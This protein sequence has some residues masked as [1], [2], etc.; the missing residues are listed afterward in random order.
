MTHLKTFL[1]GSTALAL[2]A[3]LACGGGGGGSSAPAPAPT[4][5]SL[6][7]TDPTS[8]TYLLKKNTALSTATHLV[9]DLV[10]PSS[11]TGSGVTATFSADAT[12]VTW[13][14]V[15]A[16][17][18]TGTFVQNGTAFNL[19]SDPK[20]LKGKVTAGILQVTAAQKGAGSPVSLGAPLLRVAL[21]LRASQLPGAISLSADATRC[22]VLDGTGTIASPITVAVGALAAQ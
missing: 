7:Y 21:D 14:N 5:T 2:G 8:G 13:A 10:G 16:A 1:T 17:D 20:I 11:A 22:Q 6:G 12:R 15:S 18:P 4:A 9:M 3:M 19:G